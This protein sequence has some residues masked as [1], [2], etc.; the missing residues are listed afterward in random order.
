[1][2]SS[3]SMDVNIVVLLKMPVMRMAI[4]VE[5][6]VILAITGS[7]WFFCS[8]RHSIILINTG[9]NTM[10]V[11]TAVGTMTAITSMF[12]PPTPVFQY[13]HGIFIADIAAVINMIIILLS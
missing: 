6:V 5:M 13:C 8:I 11:V 12:L 9:I 4:I 1:M 10:V 7:L 3:R 2:I